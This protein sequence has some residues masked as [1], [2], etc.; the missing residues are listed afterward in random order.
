MAVIIAV[1]VAVVV[2]VLAVV[3]A[4]VIAVVVAVCGSYTTG[5]VRFS[6]SWREVCCST[7][8]DECMPMWINNYMQYVMPFC[9]LRLPV[10]LRD[11]LCDH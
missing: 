11:V 6:L 1:V 3:V 4:V 10:A 5:L 7:S 8:L 9:Q 2:V